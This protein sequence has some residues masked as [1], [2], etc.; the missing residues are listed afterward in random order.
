MFS[1]PQTSSLVGA[2]PSV[3]EELGPLEL[4]PLE[5]GPLLLGLLLLGAL[6][7]GAL[8]LGALDLLE[9]LELLPACAMESVVNAGTV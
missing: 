2:V 7:L 9:L 4:G 6:A 8:A 1:G 3:P 5:L